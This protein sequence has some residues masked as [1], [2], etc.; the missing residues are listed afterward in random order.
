MIFSKYIRKIKEITSHGKICYIIHKPCFFKYQDK[1]TFADEVKVLD[2]HPPENLLLI[3]DDLGLELKGN[4]DLVKIFEKR[5]TR[6]SI[7]VI[8]I[9]QNIFAGVNILKTFV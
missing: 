9:L 6:R 5:R 2:I 7:S 1:E 4:E 3:V 8:F